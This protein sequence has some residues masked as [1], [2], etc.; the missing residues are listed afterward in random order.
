VRQSWDAHAQ[1]IDERSGNAASLFHRP[2]IP[3][4]PNQR[5]MLASAVPS[6]AHY[7]WMWS[8]P[9]QAMTFIRLFSFQF[10]VWSTTL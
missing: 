8:S 1:W 5:R 4:Q 9:L 3:E 2:L 10:S 7:S 6:K